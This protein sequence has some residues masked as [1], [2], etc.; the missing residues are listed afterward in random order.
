VS[1]CIGRAGGLEGGPL[2]PPLGGVGGRSPPHGGS[3]AAPSKK[4]FG[5]TYFRRA[6]PTYFRR[7]DIFPGRHISGTT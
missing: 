3:G 1:A 2:G 6:E 5:P 7:V 4:F